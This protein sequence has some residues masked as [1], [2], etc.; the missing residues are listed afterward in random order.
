MTA[1]TELRSATPTSAEPG[2]A[3]EPPS[4]QEEL[5]LCGKYDARDERLVFFSPRKLWSKSV[6]CWVFVRFSG[7]TVLE[8][9]CCLFSGKSSSSWVRCMGAGSGLKNVDDFH[10]QIHWSLWSKSPC[11]CVC[12]CVC[13]FSFLFYFFFGGGGVRV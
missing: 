4:R 11:V 8:A 13:F 2:A 1:I 7:R 10:R 6:L 5:S 12:V 3:I 9:S